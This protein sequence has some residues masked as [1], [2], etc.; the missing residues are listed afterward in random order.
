MFFF[1]NKKNDK[2]TRNIIYGPTKKVMLFTNARNEKNMREWAAHHLLIGF[3]KIIIFDHKSIIPLKEV[4]KNFDRRVKIIDVS[5]LDNSIKLTLMS[6]ASE[7]AN[8]LKL[9]WMI[10]LDAD[11]FI[12]LNK[13][14]DV[15]DLLSI[16]N[17]ADSLGVNWLFF[18]SNYLKNDPDGLVLENYTKSDLFLNDH[19]KSFVRPSKIIN[20]GN[21]HF[22]NIKN[23]NRYYGINNVK[24]VN[25]YNNK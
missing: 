15:K 5:N 10:Y 3:D 12:I 17:H 9:D 18:G 21:P 4:F 13:F 1:K 22:Y 24:L 19:L 8:Y 23:P 6:K 16:Y 14:K 7:I 20:P 25:S 2:I 11:E